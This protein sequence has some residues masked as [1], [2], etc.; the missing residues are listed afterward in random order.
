MA[1]LE[2]LQAVAALGLL[3]SAK[4]RLP[5]VFLMTLKNGWSLPKI[6]GSGTNFLRV[7]E[8]PG[9]NDDDFPRRWMEEMSSSDGGRPGKWKD[10]DDFCRPWL[11]WSSKIGV[12]PKWS[13]PRYGCG[14]K[15]YIGRPQLWDLCHG[16]WKQG[17]KPV[18]RV[19]VG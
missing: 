15:I 17:R 12:T 16:M 11:R 10:D 14:Q 1:E 8:T 13:L 7:V 2:A 9:S 4:K 19:L 18:V 3:A 5:R 6:K